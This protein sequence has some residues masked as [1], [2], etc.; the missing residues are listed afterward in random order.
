MH[1]LADLV[2]VLAQYG[3]SAIGKPIPVSAGTLNWNY[4][5]ETNAGPRF[6]RC[7]RAGVSRERIAEEHAL[8]AWLLD[9][10]VPVA[11]AETTLAGETVVETGDALWA[12]FPW[13][14]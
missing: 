12:L 2:P 3:V 6:L 4:R 1:E 11:C 14:A 10:S 7:H 5:V 9:R 13:I 8:L